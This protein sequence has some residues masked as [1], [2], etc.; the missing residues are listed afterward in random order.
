MKQPQ[1]SSIKGL[2]YLLF[3]CVILSHQSFAQN[4]EFGSTSI[5]TGIGVGFNDGFKETGAGFIYAI[6]WQKHLGEHQRIRLNPNLVF[7]GF[8]SAGITD[9]RDQFY[10][11]TSLGLNIHYDLLRYK[12]FSIVTTGGGFLNYSRGLLGTGGWPEANNHQSEYFNSLYFGGQ[13]SLALRI[14]PKNSRLAYEL[15]PINAQLGNKQFELI[16][17][18][19]GIDIKLKP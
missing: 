15:R 12:S 14:N 19:F 6:G 11:I 9:T 16:Y 4:T 8:T 2:T 1:K 17:F 3:F 5:K 7:G 10:R 18:M 13:L